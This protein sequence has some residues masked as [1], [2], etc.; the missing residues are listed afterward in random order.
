MDKLMKEFATDLGLCWRRTSR[1][2]CF[3]WRF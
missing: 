1:E 2:C 3:S